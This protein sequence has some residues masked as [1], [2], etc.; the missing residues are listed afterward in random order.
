MQEWTRAHPP[1]RQ[2]ADRLLSD[3]AQG[4]HLPGSY[5]P[6]E[7][8]LI[9]RF[10]RSRRTVRRALETMADLEIVV[11]VHSKGWMV[12]PLDDQGPALLHRYQEIAEDLSRR[13]AVG[14]YPL[15]SF[16]PGE[17]ELAQAYQCSRPTMRKALR[18]LQEQG[19]ITCL[20][21]IG[22]RVVYTGP[23]KAAQHGP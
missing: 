1:Y 22:R 14:R 21:G 23:R 5:L 11:A 2:I 6:S 8:A 15:G 9:A 7:T 10:Q 4:V 20:K 19:R 16:L 12:R 3:I 18:L 13:I 17:L